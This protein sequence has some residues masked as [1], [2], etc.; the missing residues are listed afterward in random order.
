MSQYCTTKE[1]AESLNW[2]RDIPEFIT[3]ETPT[4]EEVDTSGTLVDG[5]IVYLDNNRIIDDTYTLYYG[6]SATSVTVLVDET[7]YTLDKDKAKVTLTSAGATKIG[8]DNVYAEYS[9]LYVD[10]RPGIKDSVISEYITSASD[11][12]ERETFQSFDSITTNVNE[13]QSGKGKYDRL[14]RV[15]KLPLN[16]VK[17]TLGA[18]LTADAT[19]V[20]LDSTT[21]LSAGMY[22]SLDD[23]AVLI[24]SVDDTT[25]L[26]VTRGQLDTTATT[27]SNDDVVVNIVVQISITP[28]GSEVS[29]TQLRY[30]YD[31]S[32]NERDYT[33][34]LLHNDVTAEGMFIGQFPERGVPDRVRLTY[35]SGYE[36]VPQT[37][38]D[39]TKI[40]VTKMLSAYTVGQSSI[41]GVSDI[42]IDVDGMLDTKLKSMLKPYKLLLIDGY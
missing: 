37:I 24:D 21:G 1:I 4:L 16:F 41:R 39:A 33:I 6:S 15:M 3:G 9:Y 13:L 22:L 29:Y 23:E 5:S 8:T 11:L 7:D 27:H 28:Y 12:I 36:T 32:V 20:T 26:T 17:T 25:T 10:G 30:S 40:L 35:S 2:V 18:D 38:K 34:T 31:Y 14:Y 42:N 19:T